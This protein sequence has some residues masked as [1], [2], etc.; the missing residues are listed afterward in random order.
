MP[1]AQIPNLLSDEPRSYY[2]RDPE[3]K[4]IPSDMDSEIPSL[5]M[6]VC[7]AWGVPEYDWGTQ[8]IFFRISGRI[9]QNSGRKRCRPALE[10]TISLP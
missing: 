7:M 6:Y 5:G 8:R 9:S 10:D 1:S 3:G 4:L 2:N